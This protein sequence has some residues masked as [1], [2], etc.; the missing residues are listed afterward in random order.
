MGARLGSHLIYYQSTIGSS[1]Y[2]M[3]ILTSMHLPPLYYSLL[4]KKNLFGNKLSYLLYIPLYCNYQKWLRWFKQ[5]GHSVKSGTW[6]GIIHYLIQLM[7]V[8][9]FNL[10]QPYFKT[11]AEI[12]I[13]WIMPR[14]LIS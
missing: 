4:F 7:I 2:L 3:I 10:G 1:A 11:C 12:M 6:I 14:F 8:Q 9:H 13:G 5:L